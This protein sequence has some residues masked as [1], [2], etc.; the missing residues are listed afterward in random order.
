MAR[1]YD[2]PGAMIGRWWRRFSRLPF[3]RRLFSFMIGRV[4]PYT[5]SIKPRVVELSPGHARW[6][7]KDRRRVRNHLKSVHAVALMN[8]AEV[9]SGTA[10]LT[11]LPPGTRG[12]VTGMSIEFFKK[13][14]GTLT[15]ECRCDIPDVTGQTRYT[16]HADIRNEDDEVVAR[17]SVDWLLERRES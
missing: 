12:I 4:V 5:G 13:A 1:T 17:A 8:L 16:V 15:A 6:R 11:A 14:R 2:A 3:G 9:T 10:M 7:M